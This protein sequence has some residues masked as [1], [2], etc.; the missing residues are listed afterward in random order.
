ML[1]KCVL[2]ASVAAGALSFQDYEEAVLLL[3]EG[4]L[5]EEALRLVRN[6]KSQETEILSG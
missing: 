1:P 4:A 5:W 6:F 3:L 2:L